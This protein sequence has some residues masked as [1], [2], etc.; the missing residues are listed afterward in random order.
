LST[1]GLW[2]SEKYMGLFLLYPPGSKIAFSV[3]KSKSYG[4]AIFAWFSWNP[5]EKNLE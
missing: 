5:P 2:F 3:V 1:E 4:K